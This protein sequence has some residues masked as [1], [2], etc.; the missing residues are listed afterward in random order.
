VPYIGY[1]F[2]IAVCV[3]VGLVAFGKIKP[4]AYPFILY[5][6]SAGMVLMTTLAGPHLVGSD[7]HLE[8]YYAQLRAGLDV[9]QP[10]VGT[11]QGTSIITYLSANI[12]VWKVVYPLLFAAIPVLLF[13]VF[14]KF[15]SNILRIP[16]A[17]PV[18][19]NAVQT[20]L[21]LKLNES[22]SIVK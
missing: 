16:A 2:I 17:E 18:A 22:L 3:V 1:A 14:R 4:R 19:G 15:F 10:E 13:Y 6:I 11:P 20:T 8:Y 7:I 12:W 9:M 5:G 21:E